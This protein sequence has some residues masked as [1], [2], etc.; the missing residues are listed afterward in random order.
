MLSRERSQQTAKVGLAAGI[1][2]SALLL[3]GAA[4]HAPEFDGPEVSRA[5]YVASLV[6]FGG[7]SALF[8]RWARQARPQTA[9]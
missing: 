5:I 4:F 1:L 2:V 9:S 8:W 6:A 3:A 7:S